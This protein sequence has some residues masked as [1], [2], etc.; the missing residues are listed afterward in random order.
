MQKWVT[1]AIPRPIQRRF[2]VRRLGLSTINVYTKFEVPVFTHYEDTKG[3]ENCRAR[4]G[5]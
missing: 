3:D 5:G 2:V 1:C 4:L